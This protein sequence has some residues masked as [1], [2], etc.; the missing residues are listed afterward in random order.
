MA[1]V[2]DNVDH[3]EVHPTYAL[4]VLF[5]DRE[6]VDLLVEALAAELDDEVVEVI[7]GEEG[8]RILDQRGV[9]HGLSARLHRLLQNWTY[10]KEILAVYSESL[11]DGEFLTVIPCPPGRRLD[12]AAAAEALGGRRIYY[13]GYG[14]VES[15]NAR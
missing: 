9:R 2:D 6:H 1:N 8:L 13:Y 7:H 5:P 11:A 10:Y 4:T 15:I 3:F 12:I 14:T